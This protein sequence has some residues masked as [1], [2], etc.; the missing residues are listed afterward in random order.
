MARLL[1]TAPGSYDWRDDALCAQSDP[2]A[3][4]PDKGGSTGPARKICGRCPVREACLQYALAHDERFG[5][6]GGLSDRERRR[7]KKNLTSTGMED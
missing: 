5:I 3:F 2:E 1:T 7:L 6:W 4:Y